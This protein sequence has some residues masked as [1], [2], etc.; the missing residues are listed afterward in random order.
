MH[1]VLLALPPWHHQGE[2]CVPHLTNLRRQWHSGLAPG[3]PVRD[4]PPVGPARQLAVRTPCSFCRVA[5]S[6]APRHDVVPP[7]RRRLEPGDE[8]GR[9]PPVAH[10]STA[11]RRH[12]IRHT[13]PVL[14]DRRDETLCPFGL[15]WIVDTLEHDVAGSEGDSLASF[16]RDRLVI[17][18]ER[19]DD[20]SWGR[21]D[22]HP[23]VSAGA[24]PRP[25][26]R[27]HVTWPRRA[28][29]RS[30][31]GRP[32]SASNRPTSSKYS[33]RA[34]ARPPKC[35]SWW[36]SAHFVHGVLRSLAVTMGIPTS[37]AGR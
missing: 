1:E 17:D 9:H 33:S 24:G 4:G 14:L 21:R 23:S 32:T 19:G 5:E 16:E 31:M 34:P 22:H 20:G 37:Q 2:Q 26:Y 27:R 12:G 28:T 15:G 10:P 7:R 18:A 8:L 30:L 11:D 35:G 29:T 13:E 6:E 3:R 36:P 25:Q